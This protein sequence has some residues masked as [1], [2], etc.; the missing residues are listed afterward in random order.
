MIDL[1]GAVDA[2]VDTLTAAGIR[3]TADIRDLNPPAVLVAP[4]DIAWRFGRGAD[5]TWRVVAAVGNTAAGP[6]ITGL[7]ELV[8]QVQAAL[9][10]AVTGGRPVDLS[11][12]DGGAPLPGYE[13]TFTTRISERT[14]P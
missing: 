1:A 8:D 11:S 10:G 12:P 4:P 13:L 3:A 9:A 2:V 6:A 14:A 7:S 5:A